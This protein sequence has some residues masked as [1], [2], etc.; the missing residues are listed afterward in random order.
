MSRANNLTQPATNVNIDFTI[1]TI[2][3]IL[4]SGGARMNIWRSL[5]KEKLV[6]A[7]YG[8]SSYAEPKPNELFDSTASAEMFSEW[9]WNAENSHRQPIK[10]VTTTEVIQ[11][12]GGYP[13]HQVRGPEVHPSGGPSCEHPHGHVGDVGPIPINSS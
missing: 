9:E 8:Y 2:P 7:G 6:R 1:V 4:R 3:C 13:A 11:T 5:T 10:V 12:I